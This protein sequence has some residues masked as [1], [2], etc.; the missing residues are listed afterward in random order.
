MLVPLVPRRVS[1][2]VADAPWL[3]PMCYYVVF[4]IVLFTLDSK[5]HTVV[6]PLSPINPKLCEVPTELC[7]WTN[8]TAH[9]V[10]QSTNALD[11]I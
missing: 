6:I 9:D 4:S 3:L 11:Q 1:Q 8:V 2:W 10:R 7:F 5:L